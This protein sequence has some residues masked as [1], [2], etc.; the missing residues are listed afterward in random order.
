MVGKMEEK[1]LV[2]C[3]TKN[4]AMRCKKCGCLLF[5]VKGYTHNFWR[6]PNLSCLEEYKVMVEIYG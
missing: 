2:N 6:C 1:K 3:K 5:L 4:E